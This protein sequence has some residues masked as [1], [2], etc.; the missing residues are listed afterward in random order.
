MGG[1]STL[2]DLAAV[3]P[4]Q[5]ETFATNFVS[6]PDRRADLDPNGPA[7][8]DGTRSLTNAVLLE[9]VRAARR[10][11]DELG[12]GAGDVVAL[13]LR[14]RVE[15]VVLLFACWRL[16]ATVTP[17]NPSLTE[18]EVMRQLEASGARLLVVEDGVSAPGAVATLA[19]GPGW[20]VPPPVDPSTLALLI[21]TSGTT[22]VPKGV[23]LDHAYQ[24]NIFY[25]TFEV[26]QRGRVP[27]DACNA[28]GG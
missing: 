27:C 13:K 7:V 21:F 25:S 4:A 28:C 19:K 22:G 2:A 20:D 6:L 14:N 17:V 16:G 10:H 3:H 18:A 24:L 9:C 1:R 12:V 11:L 26:G 8:S 15:F 5:R 23:M